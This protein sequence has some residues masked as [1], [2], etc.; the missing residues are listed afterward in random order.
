LAA[1]AGAAAELGAGA[2]EGL[3]E[4]VVFFYRHEWPRVRKIREGSRMYTQH[5]C[6]LWRS[7][8]WWMTEKNE[9]APADPDV[10]DE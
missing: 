4:D 7:G 1:A 3:E 5:A 10:G 8:P 2:D 6:V 9:A